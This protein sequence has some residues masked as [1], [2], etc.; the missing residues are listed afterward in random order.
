[1][2]VDFIKD[3][4]IQKVVDFSNSEEIIIFNLW[5]FSKN[6]SGISYL[7]ELNH[8]SQWVKVD[9]TDCEINLAINQGCVVFPLLQ[10]HKIED[11]ENLDYEL[12]SWTT[13]F[14]NAIILKLKKIFY[15]RYQ[16]R[17]LNQQEKE[18]ESLIK[19]Y[20]KKYDYESY[21]NMI[22]NFHDFFEKNFNISSLR[23]MLNFVERQIPLYRLVN[24]S[25]HTK[26]CNNLKNYLPKHLS[27]LSIINEKEYIYEINRVNFTSPFNFVE[28]TL[29]FIDDLL[30]FT[31]YDYVFF[32]NLDDKILK[33]LIQRE[34]KFI[35][36][37][38]FFSKISRKYV[39]NDIHLLYSIFTKIG[40]K[41]CLKNKTYVNGLFKYFH[42]KQLY[43][44]HYDIKYAL[45]YNL[46]Q[47]S[48]DWSDNCSENIDYCI[49]KFEDSIL[50]IRGNNIMN[51]F[52]EIHNKGKLY[53]SKH[54][55]TCNFSKE[56][57]ENCQIFCGIN[58]DDCQNFIFSIFKYDNRSLLLGG[59]IG[60]DSSL[61]V[62]LLDGDSE[63]C[64]CLYEN[65]IKYFSQFLRV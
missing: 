41:K 57:W 55:V 10:S 54:D 33:T 15:L 16:V 3:L 24:L 23:E 45:K 28:F 65:G 64:C 35:L 6:S 18:L 14:I 30:Y 5:K 42:D 1:M 48:I 25:I 37:F 58:P 51:F 13:C 7:F 2:I 12:K 50:N 59:T 39:I 32:I 63:N 38:K 62:E 11:L 46:I 36:W 52:D 40:L 31:Q 19:K 61:Y 20:F 34:D 22:Y 60:F 26:A 44:N 47:N 9:F 49:S 29:R 27:L 8:E 56:I 43:N 21:L 4:G 17:I 53:F